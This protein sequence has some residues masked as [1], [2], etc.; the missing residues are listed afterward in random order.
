MAERGLVTADE[1]AAG[2]SLHAPKAIRRSSST[3]DRV[4]TALSK[5]G[6]T[7]R[8][9][10]APQR[11]QVGDPVRARNIHP[12]GHTRLPRYVRGHVGIVTH[13]H[14][15]HVLP[16]RQLHGPRR[17]PA[18]ALHGSLH[19]ARALGRGR[20]P[21]E[22]GLGR[23]VGKLSGTEMT[24]AAPSPLPCPA[25]RAR[26]TARSS[27]NHG[28]RMRS[29]WFSRCTRKVSFT[30]PEWAAALSDEI[31]AAQAAGDPD[32]GETYYSHWLAALE[33]IVATKKVT[34]PDALARYHAA[35]DAAA[36]RTPHGA[37]DRAARGRFSGANQVTEDQGRQRAV[38]R[39]HSLRRTGCQ[40]R[41]GESDRED[42]AG[43]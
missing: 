39:A 3:A 24:A 18:V 31:K 32:T 22:L 41:S 17:G 16:G 26:R 19:R 7:T 14:G 12:A 34:S 4:A 35:W 37:A 28:R 21:D 15:V 23:C 38:D 33:K 25:C 10:S 6:P 9:A 5:G 42:A 8:P 29:R 2:K 40:P 43:G 13:V 36:D 30:W 11:F 20:G 27:P 1:V